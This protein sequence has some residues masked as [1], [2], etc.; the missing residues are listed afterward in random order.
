MSMNSF[1][2]EFDL[3]HYIK[4]RANELSSGNPSEIVGIGDDSAVTKGFEGFESIST[5]ML[6]EFVDFDFAWANPFEVGRKSLE[7]SLSDISAMGSNPTY[8]MLTLAIP[9]ERF[10]RSF[11]SEF[12]DGY[13]SSAKQSGVTLIGGDISKINGPF[14]VDSAVI[15]RSSYPPILRSGA[16]VGDLIFVTG[17]LGGAAAGLELLKSGKRDLAGVE[18]LL[19]R[20]LTPNARTE[21]GSLLGASGIVT[22]MIDVSDGFIGDLHHILDSSGVGA[23]VDI[24]SLPIDDGISELV[25]RGILRGEFLKQ[26]DSQLSLDKWFALTGGEDFELVFT[27]SRENE[28]RLSELLK[29]VKCSKVGV[30]SSEAGIGRGFQNGK[31][32]QLPKTSFTHF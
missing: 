6:I 3:I 13:I 24:E 2:N 23:E 8:S 4:N 11:L 29:G 10:S 22:S 26:N 20:Q 30:V 15:G 25:T 21:L 7:V 17:E 16:S 31:S 19:Q 1:E 14:I 18:G 28:S 5:D 27:V 32:F 9:E 12:I